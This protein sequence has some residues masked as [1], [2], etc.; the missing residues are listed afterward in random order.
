[1][2]LNRDFLQA[3]AM[4]VACLFVFYFVVLFG[5]VVFNS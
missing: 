3:C 4:V 1:M 5:A 2:K